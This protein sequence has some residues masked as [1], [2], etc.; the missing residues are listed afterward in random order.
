MNQELWLV[1]DEH[2]KDEYEKLRGTAAVLDSS[3]YL[4]AEALA[5]S[6]ARDRL[7]DAPP[8]GA[9]VLEWSDWLVVRGGL[10]LAG[11]APGPQAE[12]LFEVAA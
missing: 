11:A 3:L 4:A 7:E 2:L 9:S 6:D 5:A 1:A 8:V 12:H 10:R